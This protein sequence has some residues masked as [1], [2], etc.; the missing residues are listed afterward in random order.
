MPGYCWHISVPSRGLWMVHWR[1]LLRWKGSGRRRHGRFTI[2]V[3]GHIVKN[4]FMRTIARF[5][6]TLFFFLIFHPLNSP[7]LIVRTASR[8]GLVSCPVKLYDA[9]KEFFLTFFVE[10]KNRC[11]GFFVIA[12]TES[13]T[14]LYRLSQ[15]SSGEAHSRDLSRS[16][17]V[18]RVKK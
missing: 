6:L 16:G 14:I 9:K 7:P 13:L 1:S 3:G 18:H 15:H 8:D 4:Q 5:F 12:C 2:F 10:Q 17:Y 11:G